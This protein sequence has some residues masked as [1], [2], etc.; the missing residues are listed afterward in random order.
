MSTQVGVKGQV[1]I[2]KPIR[3]ALGVEPG[4]VAVQRIVG[5]RVEIAFY[6]PD[7]GS[8]LRGAL[9]GY[10]GEPV[11]EY[12]EAEDRAWTAAARAKAQADEA[13]EDDG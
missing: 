10:I 9:S 11:A 13:G 6:P 4:Y 8:S 7:H 2:E 3:K 1:V 12:G 5:H